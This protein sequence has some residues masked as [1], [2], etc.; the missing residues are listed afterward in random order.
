MRRR[1]SQSSTVYTAG[2]RAFLSGLLQQN[3]KTESTDETS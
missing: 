3:G 2:M 1:L